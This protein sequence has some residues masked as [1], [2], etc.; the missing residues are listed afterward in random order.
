LPET[1]RHLPGTY[2]TDGHTLLWV[3]ER[4]SSDTLLAENVKNGQEIEMG[5]ADLLGYNVVERK[6]RDDD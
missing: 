1:P 4:T 3:I 6:E 5:D 2:L